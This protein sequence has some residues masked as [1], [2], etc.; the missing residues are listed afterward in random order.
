MIASC[1]KAMSSNVTDVE[2]EMISFFQETLENN[3]GKKAPLM[4]MVKALDYYKFYFILKVD[5]KKFGGI[6]AH[7]QT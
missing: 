5:R 4:S 1:N 6:Y 2:N 7:V 3:F